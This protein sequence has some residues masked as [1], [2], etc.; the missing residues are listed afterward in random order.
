MSGPVLTSDVSD[1]P[2]AIERLRRELPGWYYKVCEC[3]VS[4]DATIAPMGESP[5]ADLAQ[6]GNPFDV[7]F[8][9]DLRQPSTLA[10]ALNG[11]IDD[12]LEARASA[13]AKAAKAA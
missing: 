7:G 4:C 11:A 12:A 8:D 2:A 6:F 10:A 1:L 9:C 3:Q 5:D 13:R